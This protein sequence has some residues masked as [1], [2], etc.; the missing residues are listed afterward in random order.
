MMIEFYN[1]EMRNHFLERLD[2]VENIS[3]YLILKK[4]IYKLLEVQRE[5]TEL[6]DMKLLKS[7]VEP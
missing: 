5:L 4:E 6:L 7:F 3:D 2:Q 1:L